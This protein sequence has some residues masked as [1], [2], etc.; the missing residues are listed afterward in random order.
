MA[1][2][3]AIGL[4]GLSAIYQN[5]QPERALSFNPF[6]SRASIA[7]LAE[8][9]TG[10]DA[11][12]LLPALDEAAQDAIRYAPINALA[13]GLMG[14]VRLGEGERHT[15]DALFDIA[16]SLSRTEANAL[17][18]TLERAIKRGDY[19]AAIEKLNIFSRRWPAHFAS[20]APVI[21]Q[22]LRTPDGYATAL[23][24]LSAEPPWRSRLLQFLDRDPGS[25]D[26]AY[27]LQLDLNGNTDDTR[28]REIGRTLSGL[29]RNKR[30]DQAYRLFL[31]TLNET[32][33]A[34]YGYVFNGGF[35]LAPS[36]RPFDWNLKS[37]PGVKISREAM[38]TADGEDFQLKLQ[39]LGKPVKRIDVSQYLYLPAGQY[40]LTLN[41][42]A[43]DLEVPKGLHLNIVCTEPK[44]T[45]S[46]I[47]VLP[48][49]Y[50]NETLE[51]NFTLPDST[52]KMFRLA[53]G[54]DLIAESFRYRYS[55]TLEID[56]VSLR[57]TDS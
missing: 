20:L 37:R 17:Q 41:V 7:L 15:A 2:V 11:L 53:M 35:D 5:I 19:R 8:G 6:N 1:T 29:L 30:Y 46:R 26:L 54:T 40:K 45:V 57:R 28:P 12:S 31:L 18:R 52:C 56:N 25:I 34:H 27:R 42:D 16:L 3:C 23:S 13:Y 32:D 49:S 48:G 21:P 33:R 47:D 51:A 44:R 38:D 9:L 4:T 43:S 14:E 36:G 10:S 55:G 24:T 39:F 50:R 22:L